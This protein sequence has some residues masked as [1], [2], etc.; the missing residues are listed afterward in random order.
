MLR[1]ESIPRANSGRADEL[2][3]HRLDVERELN[4]FLAEVVY[5]AKDGVGA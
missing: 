2:V 4:A 5:S 1:L 3:C